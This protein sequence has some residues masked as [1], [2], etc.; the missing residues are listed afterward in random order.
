[1]LRC[2]VGRLSSATSGFERAL[3]QIAE[4]V[5]IASRAPV[6]RA[7]ALHARAR[8]GGAE[9]RMLPGI[10]DD[11]YVP[12]PHNQVSRMWITHPQ[13]WPR[14]EV[15]IQRAGVR[16]GIPCLLIE[17]VNQVRTVRSQ[18]LFVVGPS[19][20]LGDGPPFFQAEEPEPWRYRRG[21]RGLCLVIGGLPRLWTW[22][23]RLRVLLGRPVACLL[24]RPRC[25]LLP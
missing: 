13:E 16:I 2:T 5:R 8:S 4:K 21:P 18:S 14:P 3:R 19:N 6:P 9:E 22:R 24:A 10:H 12:A 17:S 1:M 23:H 25:A 11:A 7:I 15:K 20:S